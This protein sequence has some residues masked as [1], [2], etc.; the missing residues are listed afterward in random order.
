MTQAMSYAM[1]REYDK[2]LNIL[3]QCRFDLQKSYARPNMEYC[4]VELMNSIG[5]V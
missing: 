2:A 1:L 4:L 3:T 5:T